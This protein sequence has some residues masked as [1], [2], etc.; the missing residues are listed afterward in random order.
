MQIGQVAVGADTTFTLALA[1]GGTPEEAS[2]NA[3]ASL[4]TPFRQ[5]QVGYEAGWHDYLTPFAAPASVAEDGGLLTQYN[6]G[7]DDAEGARGQDATAART[8]PR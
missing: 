1:F 3:A 2:G 8:S 7:A 6:V 4:A 5:Q